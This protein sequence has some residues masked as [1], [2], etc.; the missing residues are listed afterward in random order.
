LI[1]ED[2]LT[3]LRNQTGKPA[4]CRHKPGFD[5]NRDISEYIRKAAFHKVSDLF[6]AAV[7]AARRP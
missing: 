1:A 4:W 6:Y 2:L 3:Y 5:A 7:R